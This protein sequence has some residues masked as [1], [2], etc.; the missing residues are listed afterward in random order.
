MPA[1]R[2]PIQPAH[3]PTVVYPHVAAVYSACLAAVTSAEQTT[4]IATDKAA[5]AAPYEPAYEAADTSSHSAADASAHC[6]TVLATTFPPI[7]TAFRTTFVASVCATSIV[8][9][10]SAVRAAVDT[11]VIPA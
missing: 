4:I 8:A 1:Y 9:H 10:P 6:S 2:L 3:C 5:R 11:T 7:C